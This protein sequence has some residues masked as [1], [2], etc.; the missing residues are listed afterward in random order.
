MTVDWIG[1][2][3]SVDDSVGGRFKYASI[4]IHRHE[5]HDTNPASNRLGFCNVAGSRNGCRWR[6]GSNASLRRGLLTPFFIKP[7]LEVSILEPT[8]GTTGFNPSTQKSYAFRF[9]ALLVTA[10]NASIYRLRAKAWMNGYG[11]MYF[12]WSNPSTTLD[13]A[14]GNVTLSQTDEHMDFVRDES[15]QLPIWMTTWRLSEGSRLIL[16]T[17]AKIV[18]PL[19]SLKEQKIDI[20]IQ[21]IGENYTEKNRHKFRLDA[22]SWDKA[23]LTKLS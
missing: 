15:I 14:T 6:S 17:E 5:Q 2:K 23:A 9:Q 1:C 13:L 7:K 18:Q 20:E 16:N 21:F 3:F 10:K 12:S 4:N 8:L 22:V 11:P 19:T